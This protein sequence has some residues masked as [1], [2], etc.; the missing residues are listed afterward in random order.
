MNR[1]YR[2][3]KVNPNWYEGWEE[4]LYNT[5]SNEILDQLCRVAC[6]IEI[7]ASDIV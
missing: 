2:P 1:Y 3:D 7:G 4:Q 6:G 5:S